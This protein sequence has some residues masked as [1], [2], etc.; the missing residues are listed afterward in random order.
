MKTTRLCRYT[1]FIIWYK[2]IYH[3]CIKHI[4]VYFRFSHL[5]YTINGSIACCPINAS[6]MCHPKKSWMISSSWNVSM[7]LIV[8]H[9]C[10]LSMRT[11]F[12][13]MPQVNL[14]MTRVLLSWIGLHKAKK[15]SCA[16]TGVQ[17]MHIKAKLAILFEKPIPCC[18]Q[19]GEI[20]ITWLNKKLACQWDVW[21]TMITQYGKLDKSWSLLATYVQTPSTGQALQ[22][23]IQTVVSDEELFVKILLC[24]IPS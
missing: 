20:L 11:W 4:Q 23:L 17:V 16:P 18:H 5:E 12:L 24:I 2:T 9:G 15:P 14:I 22:L 13:Q 19:N 8:L 6:I 10:T 7:L 1:K 3:D 21:F